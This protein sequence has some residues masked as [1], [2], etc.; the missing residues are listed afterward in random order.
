[1]KFYWNCRQRGR[2]R[3]EKT[4]VYW[5][6]IAVSRFHWLHGLRLRSAA[7]RLL[8][9]WA[10][11]SVCCECCVLW[12]QVEVSATGSSLVRR[13]PTECGVSGCD[14]EALVT[15]RPW[16]TTGY[17]AIQKKNSGLK[18]IKYVSII[19]SIKQNSTVILENTWNV[20]KSYILKCFNILYIF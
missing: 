3:V 18:I 13:S 2:K 20:D 15:R 11:M 8:E 4:K 6:I 16:S 7:V 19:C 17:G 14:R 12:C 9:L 1:M 10:R 5:T